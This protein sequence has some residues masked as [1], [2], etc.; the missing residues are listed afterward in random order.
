MVSS[1]ISQYWPET[2]LIWGAGATAGL[3]LAGTDKIGRIISVLAGISDMGL[4]H[5]P[6]QDRIEKAFNGLSLH[7]DMKKELA[8]LLLILYDG[9]GARNNDEASESHNEAVDRV[10]KEMRKKYGYTRKNTEEI[11]YTLSNLHREYDWIGVRSIVK[12]IARHWDATKE[13]RT[14][15]ELVDL[16][17]TVDQLF[18]MKLAMP[19]EELFFP[20]GKPVNTIYMIG[21]TRLIAVKNCL[22]YLMAVIQKILYQSKPL[23]ELKKIVKPYYGIALG[24]SELMKEEALQFSKRKYNTDH[25]RFYL[26]S[27]ALI[28]FNWDPVILW[29]IF[30][31]HKKSNASPVRIGKKY[32]R[33]FNDA[34]D[35]IGFRKIPDKGDNAEDLF[36]LMMNE[37]ACRAVNNPRYKKDSRLMRI[38][39]I[40][41]P[42]A[43]FGWR[44]CRRCGKLFTDFGNKWD[45]YSSLP[46]G[47]D[48][49]PGLQQHW[50]PRTK[51]EEKEWEKGHFS[52][53]QCI[54]CGE[55]TY[56]YDCPIILQ[57]A[58]KSDRHYV[59]DGIFR[60]MGQIIGN[61][62]HLVFAGYSL[63]KDDF[64]YRCF[65]QSACAGQHMKGEK[66]CTLISYDEEYMKK[67]SD[68]VWLEAKEISAYLR[69]NEGDEK[70][71][72]TVNNLLQIYS[73]D[74]IRVTFK[75]IPDIFCKRSGMSLEES[76]KDVIYWTECFPEGF[77][78]KR[79]T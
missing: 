65:F 14:E 9:D 62:R 53:I 66:Y 32:L 40:L 50:K 34:G 2:A 30:N 59:L 3:G 70:T 49:L 27:Y 23:T 71:K 17:T 33:L 22:I 46:F 38:G 72:T 58:I 76:L 13:E 43:G 47:P 51:E 8:N 63:P 29:L 41:F 5:S 69:G 68:S 45:I 25:R 37:Q 79:N 11:K 35:G 42:H 10:S 36:A 52:A 1:K 74:H 54:F 78:P 44:I 73:Q 60:E 16:L 19:T 15:I 20:K 31:A 12:Y 26:Y 55:M 21:D 28:S 57:S 75:G 77:P 48:L 24:L 64:I 39:K 67:H 7:A 6:L 4:M 56:A 18:E 61:A